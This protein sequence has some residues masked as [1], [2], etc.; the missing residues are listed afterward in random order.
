MDLKRRTPAFAIGVTTL[1][2]AAFVG[3]GGAAAADDGTDATYR[4]TVA[5]LAPGQPLTPPL[6]VLHEAD[7]TIVAPGEAAS[8]GLQ[9]LAE[10]GNAEV[11]IDELDGAAGVTSVTV[12]DH[13]IVSGGIPGAAE[14]PSVA[15]L[16]VSADGGADRITVASMLICTND[17][18]SIV[19]DAELPSEV[20][21]RVAYRSEAYDAGTEVNTEAFA[22]LVP[23]CQG[24]V[25]VTGEA[26]GTGMTNP[27]L[28]EGGVVSPHPGIAGNGDLT[29][30][31]HTI[32]PAPAL[33]VVE[34]IA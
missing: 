33:V 14:V 25:G 21:E 4:V 22:D 29:Q 10:N 16:E 7:A 28:A 17:G 27:E 26:E 32:A 6:V 30:D 2:A 1:A 8:E 19:H 5:N 34:R 31:A 23:P 13:P 24:L 15:S 11:W 18:L 3:V 12:A 20:G 9:Q